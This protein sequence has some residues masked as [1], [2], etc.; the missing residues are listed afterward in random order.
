MKIR[1][2]ASIAASV[3]VDEETVPVGETV[4]LA[5]VAAGI[6]ER[7]PN[8]AADNVKSPRELL[9]SCSYLVNGKAARGLEKLVT[10]ADTVDVLPRFAGG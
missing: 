1:Y 2:F 3:G 6:A 8:A 10:D 5:D 9:P 4:T 7:Y